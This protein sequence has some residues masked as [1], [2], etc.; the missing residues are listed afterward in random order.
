MSD[1]AEISNFLGPLAW[2]RQ[3]LGLLTT[4]KRPFN[5]AQFAEILENL[6]LFN[7]LAAGLQ[8]FKLDDLVCAGA[9]GRARSGR[10]AGAGARGYKARNL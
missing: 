10:L 5:G 1:V 2:I 4:L 7:F 3:R 8:L 9:A 6:F